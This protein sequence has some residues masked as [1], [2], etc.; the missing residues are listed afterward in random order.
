MA[1]CSNDWKS[2]SEDPVSNETTTEQPKSC[3][4]HA[5]RKSKLEVKEKEDGSWC[6]TVFCGKRRSKRITSE[7][8][9]STR[10]LEVQNSECAK[11]IE[12]LN[13]CLAVFRDH[14]VHIAKPQ[15]CPEIRDRIRETRRKC[16]DLCI[17]AHEIIMPQIRSDVSEGIPVDSQQLVNLVCC[18]QLF[19]RELKKCH[20]LVQANPMDMTAYYEKRPRSSGVSVLDKL[21]LFK[22]PPRDYH[23]EELQSIFRDTEQTV[24]LLRE[25]KEFMPCESNDKLLLD[26]SFLRWNK[27]TR[28]SVCK[29]AE[30]WM[31]YCGTNLA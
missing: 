30:D 10:S 24:A 6:Q 20:N 11:I 25:M 5:F 17:S 18:T 1:T 8:V 28:K 3:L 13:N 9:E 4:K 23:K 21:V 22:M 19:L 14:L 27:R 2:L 15:D 16:L 12:E 7:M 26:E 31:C 29:F